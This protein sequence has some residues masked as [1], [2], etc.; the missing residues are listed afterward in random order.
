MFWRR[1]ACV[2]LFVSGFVIPVAH[3]TTACAAGAHHAALIIDTG[4][5]VVRRCVAFDEESISGQQMLDRADVD[6]VYSNKY[7]EAFI[8]SIL[9]VGN[10]QAHCPN[11]DANSNWVYWQAA[12][13]SNVYLRPNQGASRTKVHDGDVE[14]WH[15][16]TGL[17]PYT[18]ASEICPAAPT[19]TAAT[20]GTAAPRNSTSTTGVGV[21]S[22][23]TRPDTDTSVGETTQVPATTESTTTST[24]AARQLA[25]PV[26]DGGGGS[27]WALV[28]VGGLIVGLGI[29]A[30]QINRR[31]AAG[32]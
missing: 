13:G 22:R 28:A 24:T 1:G 23:I 15:W 2:V 19:T 3:A 11:S 7:S 14:G 25:L 30:W 12:A 31:R 6:V 16:Q 4:D 17:P 5:R 29:G 20:G 10:D 21:T 8:C 26:D 32:G 18:P 27:P 9:G